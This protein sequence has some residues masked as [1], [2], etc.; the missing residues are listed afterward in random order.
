MPHQR[1][2]ERW[3]C[4]QGSR[5]AGKVKRDSRNPVLWAGAQNRAADSRALGGM[6]DAAAFG[7]V[8]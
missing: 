1:L 2:G 4:K 8:T 5:G 7:T 3:T 6:E